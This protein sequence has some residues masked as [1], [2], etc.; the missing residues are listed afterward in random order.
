MI[1]E[2]LYIILGFI[3]GMWKGDEIIAISIKFLE[4][5]F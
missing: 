5:I 1:K 3:I 4:T 2:I